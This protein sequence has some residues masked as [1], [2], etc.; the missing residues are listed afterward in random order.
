[1]YLVC[2]LVRGFADMAGNARGA[3]R[4]MGRKVVRVGTENVSGRTPGIVKS[5]VFKLSVW[6]S[7]N[8]QASKKRIR[9]IDRPLLLGFFVLLHLP[10]I[11]PF[12][13]SHNNKRYPLL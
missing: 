1:V 5:S 2:I 13:A 10:P 4:G 11:V 12:S 8:G 7:V 3:R 9:R 6:P